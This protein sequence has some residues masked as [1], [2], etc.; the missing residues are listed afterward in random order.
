MALEEHADLVLHHQLVDGQF[1]AG[2]LFLE[3]AF[4]L[5]AL[6]AP[7]VEIGFVD[8]AAAG[9][10]DVVSE[11]ELML[12]LAGLERV[13]E[14]LVLGVADGDAPPVAVLLVGAL[15]FLAALAAE[16]AVDQRRGVPVV[17]EEHE[18]RIAPGPGAVALER[19]DVLERLG[20]PRVDALVARERVKRV[21]GLLDA[22]RDVVTFVLLGEVEERSLLVVAVHQEDLADRTHQTEERTLEEIGDLAVRVVDRADALDREIVADADMEIRAIGRGGREGAGVEIRVAGLRA[23]GMRIALDRED[24]GRAG[25]T[26]RGEAGFRALGEA[27]GAG[28]TIVEPVEI[29]GVRG[30]AIEDDL[31]GLAGGQGRHR[32]LADILTLGRTELQEGLHRGGRQQARRDG[33]IGGTTEDQRDLGEFGKGFRE[34]VFA[35]EDRTARAGRIIAAALPSLAALALLLLRGSGR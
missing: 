1:P 12:R 17:I 9:A 29:F 8:A 33:L 16:A 31:R 19:A 34:D 3:G 6:A 35:L 7:F 15:V 21:A 23:F 28:L 20:V 32:R 18:E 2:T 5:L 26:L 30:E 25:R 4:A 10:E 13:L 27:A 11:D 14:P 22:D 24:E